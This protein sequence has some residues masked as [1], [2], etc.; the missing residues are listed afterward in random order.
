VRAGDV[1]VVE[2]T[3]RAEGIAVQEIGTLTADPRITKGTA[4]WRGIAQE[5]F[6]ASSWHGG[7]LSTLLTEVL[8]G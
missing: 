3:L 1:K 8:G 4:P 2:K 5:R 7:E 6:S